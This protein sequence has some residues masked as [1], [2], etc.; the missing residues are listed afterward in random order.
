[1]AK[2]PKIKFVKFVR[3]RG[4]VYAYF[5]TG[6][7]IDGKVLWAPMP[8]PSSIGF[9]DSYNTMLGHRTRRAD[10]GSSVSA[11]AD[12]FEASAEFGRLSA[13]AQKYYSCALRRI[14]EHLGEFPV[15]KVEP[16]HVREVVNNRMTGNGARNAFIA[17]MGLLYTFARRRD[18]TTQQPIKDIQ[19]FAIGS[20]EPW[21][22]ELL[23]AGLSAEHDRTRLAI[24][25][26]Y[27]TGQRIGDVVKM[28]WSDIRNGAIVITQQKTGKPLTIPLMGAL[29]A[30]LARTPK[31]GITII[32]NHLGRP[33]T[34]QVIRRELKAFGDS[35]GE[36]VVPHG[37][38]KNAVNALLEAG[39]TIAEV[40]AVTG[41]T[42]KV[43]EYYARRVSQRHLG[44]AAILK[45][46]NRAGKFKQS[47]KQARKAAE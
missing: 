13:G 39:C 5:R 35:L 27:H 44:E 31:Q 47:E 21:P 34:P 38:R 3:S 40:G 29:E 19:K 43:I 7:K 12:I 18:L 36:T 11:L 22:Q 26:L 20:H 16:R 32:T 15:D 25:L 9:H 42:Y 10:P 2:L 24:N 1:M 41:Q 46:E 23:E 17:V 37:L 45:L 28:R 14:R 8:P 30:E 4:K 33:M 6:Q